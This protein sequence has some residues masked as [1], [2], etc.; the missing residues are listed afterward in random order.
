MKSINIFD[1]VGDFGEDKDVAASL[2]EGVIKPAVRCGDIV[3][4]FAGVTL[5]TQSFVHALI[6]DI[7]RTSGEETLDKIEFKNCSTVVQGII[8][9]VVQY[10]LDTM[11]DQDD[12]P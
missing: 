3:L 1:M 9:T 4:D 5:V 7:L 6:S 2:R 8:S 12:G 10:S 11:Q